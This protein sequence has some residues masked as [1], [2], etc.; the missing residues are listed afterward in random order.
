MKNVQ[1]KMS[2]VRYLKRRLDKVGFLKCN[3]KE[4]RE[5]YVLSKIEFKNLPCST[6][7]FHNQIVLLKIL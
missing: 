6:K 1:S 7:F 3:F 2:F 5:F 4:T